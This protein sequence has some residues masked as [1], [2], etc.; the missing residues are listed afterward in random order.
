MKIAIVTQPLANNYGGIMQNYALQQAL[1]KLGHD[2]TTIDYIPHT[3][4]FRY[5]LS[6]CKSL[7]LFPFK[8][9]RRK[10]PKFVKVYE[11]K[12]HMLSFI[13]KHISLTQTVTSYSSAIL[14]KNNID[15]VIVG[16]DQ[17]WRPK[18]NRLIKDMYLRF[19]PQEVRKVAY[20]ASFGVDSWE[21]SS[22]LTKECAKYA[23][24]LYKLSV[25]EYSGIELCQRYLG[26]TAE[27][28]LDPTLLLESEV[29]KRLFNDSSLYKYP[30]LFAY[31]LDIDS[32][33][34]D[35]VYKLAKMLNLQPIIYSAGD[36]KVEEWLQTICYADY[37]VT[38]SFH[39]TAF[40][41]IFKK[42]FTAITNPLRGNSRFVSLL[43]SVGLFDRIISEN[44]DQMNL[45]AIDWGSVDAQL[46]A[47]RQ[48][49]FEFINN[50]LL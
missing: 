26:V 10:F 4:V 33:K 35:Y 23:Q 12:E 20:A 29:Y 48:Q 22:S 16:S 50:S 38:D 19:V 17:V 9:K 45:S 7:L 34:R 37:V 47:M 1:R 40:S 14:Y 13:K 24:Q 41:I 25:R 2:V 15:A 30:Y 6:W 49:S 28:V 5:L 46:G 11:R 32:P 8:S 43:N 18:Y 27:F 36:I 21:Y 31:I 39:G 44:Y 3:S 42:D